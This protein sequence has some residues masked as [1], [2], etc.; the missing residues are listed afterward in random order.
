MDL[1]DLKKYIDYV[2]DSRSFQPTFADSVSKYALDASKKIRGQEREPALLIHGMLPRVG[3]VY[4]GELLRLHPDLDAYP[5]QIWEVPFLQL[6]DELLHTQEQFMC[7][8]RHNAGKLGDHDFLPVFGAALLAYL[9]AETPTDKRLLLKVPSVQH[10][11]S[12]FCMFPHEHLLVLLRD[13]RD[14]VESTIKTWPQLRFSFVCR[15]WRRAAR[16]VL[17]CHERFCQ[18]TEGY[19]LARYEDAVREPQ[20]FV[21]EACRRFCLNE[22][23]YPVKRIAEIAVHG[24]SS[25]SVKGD[26][27]WQPVAKPKDFRPTGRWCDWPAS[28]KRIFKQI[29]GR[30]LVELGYASDNDW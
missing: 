21:M 24:S 10:L 26:V 7:A 29:A 12:F 27:S 9:Q 15:R 13:G 4:V 25:L 3:T 11:D 6:R 23:R 5:R 14:V 16:M 20:A 18:R 28:K 30:E 2:F 17:A 1:A 19:W 22:S 8:Y